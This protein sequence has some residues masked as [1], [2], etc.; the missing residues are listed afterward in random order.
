MTDLQSVELWS[1]AGVACLTGVVHTLLGPDHY[2]PFVAMSKAGCWSFRK[3]LGVTWV[4]GLGHVASSIVLGFIGIALGLAVGQL[5]FLEGMRG[6]LAGWLL[7]GFGMA[8]LAWGLNRALRR[9][10]HSHGH[11]QPAGHIQSHPHPHSPDEHSQAHTPQ[12][13][14]A[15]ARTTPWVLFTIF[16]FGPCE[17]LIPLL[18]YPAAESSLGGV[19]L[20]AGLFALTTL[21][22]MTV[23]VLT[24][25]KGTSFLRFPAAERYGHAIAGMSI[26]ACG[27]AIKVGL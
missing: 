15:G 25:L 3:T 27:I 12:A 7:I 2:I 9:R 24:M 17:P 10:T 23:V 11:P 19:L 22:T 6:G 4:C 1:L 21:L 18:M 8:Y 13:E 16:L 26:L 5:E 14:H 20:V